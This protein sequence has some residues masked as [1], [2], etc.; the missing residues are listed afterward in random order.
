[1]TN[2]ATIAR[3]PASPTPHGRQH[4]HRHRRRRGAPPALGLLDNF[5]RANANTLGANWSQTTLLG[6]A[7]SASTATRR[8][9]CS[10]L[11][12]LERRDQRL[13]RQAGRGVHVRQRPGYG[14]VPNG[15]FLKASGGT[16]ASP[17]NYIRVGYDGTGSVVVATTT[18]SG[19]TF[20]TRATFAATF[21][22]GDTLVRPAAAP[23]PSMVFK[24][25]GAVDHVPRQRHDPDAGAGAWTQGTGGAG[26]ACSSRPA[27]RVD[28]FSGGTVPV[29]RARLTDPATVTLRRDRP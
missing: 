6:A 14:I 29:T 9:R 16:A 17:A 18:N 7:A 2:T 11:G 24:T 19:G 26:S 5:N 8:T 3:Q 4:R 1:M 25:S 13:R 22:A 20:T 12:D 21:A 23:A 27:S 15:L 28:N 10:R